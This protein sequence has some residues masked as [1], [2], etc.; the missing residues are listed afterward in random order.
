MTKPPIDPDP[1][2]QLRFEQ[3]HIDAARYATDD[4]NPFHDPHRWHEIRA[5]PYGGPIVL[6]FQ[7]ECLIDHRIDAA[8]QTETTEKPPEAAHWSN[9]EFRFAGALRPREAFA[10]RVRRSIR[11]RPDQGEQTSRA[12]LRTTEGRAILIGSRA[13]GPAPRVLANWRPVDPRA[14]ADAQDRTVLPGTQLFLKRKYLNTSNAKTFLLGSLV[15]PF[16]YFDEISERVLF[17]PLFAASL[18]SCAL[19]ERGQAIGCDFKRDPHV[20][21]SH[22]I[23]VDQRLQQRLRSN[24]RLDL[25]VEAP[26]AATGGLGLGNTQVSHDRYRCLGVVFGQ[27]VLLRAEVHTAPLHALLE[28]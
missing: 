7:L 8:R 19:L 17:P 14:C 4:F 10:A 15:D 13:D 5:N 23:S 28:A 20:Y 2:A 12:M 21:V 3:C 11:S 6:G 16:E 27:E 26:E 18:L 9:Y 24:D 1:E 25:V 22:R